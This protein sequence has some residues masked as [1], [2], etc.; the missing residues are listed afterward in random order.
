MFEKAYEPST[1]LFV[2]GSA[3]TGS[4]KIDPSSAAVPKYLEIFKFLGR[5]HGI[6]ILHGF[7]IDPRLISLI[8]PLIG[9]H[10]NE[11]VVESLIPEALRDGIATRYVPITLT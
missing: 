8:F 3:K 2:V 1:S 6:A 10:R 7:L 11:G 4:L 9:A 5:M